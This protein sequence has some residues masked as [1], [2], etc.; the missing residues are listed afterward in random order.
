MLWGGSFVA[1]KTGL[2]FIPPVIF[3][4]LRFYVGAAFLLSYVFLTA[5]V[6]LPQTRGDWSALLASGLF[7]VAA[8]NALLFVG[9]QYTTSGI[10]AVIYGLNPVLTPAFMRMFL[11]RQKLSALDVAGLLVGLAGVVIIAQPDPA[12]LLASDVVGKGLI[13]LAAAFVAL[14]SV[15]V[16]RSETSLPNTVLTAW[17]LLLGAVTMHLA[18]LGLGQS[19]A[20]VQWTQTAVLSL[21]YL[22]AFATAVAYALYFGLLEDIGPLHTNLVAYSVPVVAAVTGWALLGERITATIV[23]GFVV[24]LFGF[25]LLKRREIGRELSSGHAAD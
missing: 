14:G 22:G 7:V 25:V 6:H 24:I 15:L 19:L 17:S 11:P 16:R 9:Q 18:A 2:A 20:G 23:A 4:S 8:N 10:A 21:L 1:I 13:L 12:N 5:G 3:A